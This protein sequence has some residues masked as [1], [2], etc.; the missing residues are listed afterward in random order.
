MAAA[1]TVTAGSLLAALGDAFPGGDEAHAAGPQPAQDVRSISNGERIPVE[2]FPD[3]GA[4]GESSEIVSQWK[5]RC[6]DVPGA[7]FEAGVQLQ[8]WGCDDTDAQRWEYGDREARTSNNLCMDVAGGSRDNGTAVQ[9]AICNGSP[10]QKWVLTNAGDLVNPASVKCVDIK[11]WKDG[12]GAKLQIW[13]CTGS[14]N[15]RW[16]QAHREVRLSGS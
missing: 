3:L 11:D 14:A 7:N 4:P 13:D 12:N 5:G 2:N 9:L 8:V 6:I 16:R 1:L 10:A 15:Q